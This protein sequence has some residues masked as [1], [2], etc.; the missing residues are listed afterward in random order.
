MVTTFT[1][2]RRGTE[3]TI[4]RVL[5][6]KRL[7]PLI[8][9]REFQRTVTADTKECAKFQSQV[10]AGRIATLYQTVRSDMTK[11]QIDALVAEYVHARLDEVDE[12]VINEG[13]D[14]IVLPPVK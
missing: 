12:F 10:W 4:A 7:Q 6:P 1:R 11:Q 14:R 2:S 9:R 8:G 3:K 5:V 13:S